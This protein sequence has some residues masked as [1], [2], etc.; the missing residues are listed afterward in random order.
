MKNN[1]SIQSDEREHRLVR[2]DFFF[3]I[4]LNIFLLGLMVASY[5]YNRS[6]GQL[7]TWFSQLIK[8]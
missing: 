2:K 8:F 4:A 6:T 5:F 3:V 7:D 1:I